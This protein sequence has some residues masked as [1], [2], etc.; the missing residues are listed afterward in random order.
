[1]SPTHALFHSTNRNNHREEDSRSRQELQPASSVVDNTPEWRQEL[2]KRMG[3]NESQITSIHR[4]I[5][6]LINTM[7]SKGHSRTATNVDMLPVKST[8]G[9]TPSSLVHSEPLQ[10]PLRSVSGNGARTCSVSVVSQEI[11]SDGAAAMD[12]GTSQTI[13]SYAFHIQ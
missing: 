12:G 3:N 1:M 4:K 2:E 7:L 6:F 13:P 9:I 5:D 10:K 8:P 11:G